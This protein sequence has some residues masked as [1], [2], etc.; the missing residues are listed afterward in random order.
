MIII[1][2]IYFFSLYAVLFLLKK[3]NKIR[4]FGLLT[5]LIFIFLPGVFFWASL[6][7]PAV[8]N[9]IGEL[10]YASRIKKFLG[11]NLTMTENFKCTCN[12]CK[13]TEDSYDVYCSFKITGQE[14]EIIEQ[15]L[16]LV[17]ED[18]T[19][20]GSPYIEFKLCGNKNIFTKSYTQNK[21]YIGESSLTFYYSEETADACVTGCL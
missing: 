10:E 8:Y 1:F 12:D 19:G 18:M 3:F 15:D 14:M 2:L 13:P 16:N 20:L 11:Q 5:I 7:V 9:F 6:T 21:P 4:R 17:E